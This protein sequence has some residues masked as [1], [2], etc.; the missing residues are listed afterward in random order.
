[1]YTALEPTPERDRVTPCALMV[2]IILIVVGGYTMMGTMHDIQQYNKIMA[3]NTYLMCNMTSNAMM[4]DV[5]CIR[6]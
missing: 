3:R 4:Q 5:Q 2:L 1:M 6:V